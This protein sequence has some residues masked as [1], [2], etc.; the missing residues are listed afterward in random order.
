MSQPAAEAAQSPNKDHP[1]KVKPACVETDDPSG[2]CARCRRLR[3]DCVAPSAK[4][5][6]RPPKRPS[7]ASSFAG[8][9]R[10]PGL[11][12]LL[13]PT[14]ESVTPST[15]YHPPHV[16]LPAF[17]TGIDALHTGTH[18]APGLSPA[19]RTLLPHTDTNGIHPGVFTAPHAEPLGPPQQIPY[20]AAHPTLGITPSSSSSQ[21]PTP[22]GPSNLRT[23]DYLDPVDR[24]ATLADSRDP[25]GLYL[26]PTSPPP[27]LPWADA[28]AKSRRFEQEDPVALSILSLAEAHALTR[29]FHRDLNPMVAVL[30]SA[31]HTTDYLRRTSTPLFA[32]VLATASKFFRKDLYPMLLSHAT[33][34][35]DRAVIAGAEDTGLVQSLM[36]LVYW[37]AP[38]DTSAWRRIGWAI[39]MGYQFRWYLPRNRPLP[40]D[41]YATRQLLD[42]ER[43]WICLSFFDRAYSRTFDLPTSIK[44]NE[45]GDVESW[46]KEHLHL[47]VPVDMHLAHTHERARLGDHWRSYLTS[48][49]ISPAYREAI[50]ADM[51][52]RVE[53]NLAKWSNA[54]APLPGYPTSELARN[55]WVSLDLLLSIKRYAFESDPDNILRLDECTAVAA[56]IVEQIEAV[57][58]Q[59]KLE[60]LQDNASCLTSV[61]IVFLRKS[62]WR[63]SPPQQAHSISLLKRL[64]TC[65]ERAAAGDTEVAPAF[66]ARFIRRVLSAMGNQSR[67][68]SR[69]PSPAGG[70]AV[71][72]AMDK[73]DNSFLAELDEFIRT[74]PGVEE[75]NML[76]EQY[77]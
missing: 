33:T 40:S 69:Y 37:K 48:G 17:D 1:S 53:A 39:R 23:A 4:K 25:N 43:T 68:V 56:L 3:L 49:E 29:L 22:R 71:D 74:S 14:T 45:L 65:H 16:S 9:S 52:G 70:Q 63:L 42:A 55:R 2:P 24:I 54:N 6:G 34:I 72:V 8:P 67:A 46:A 7:D 36:L 59:G 75:T 11:A 13:A 28:A 19:S 35:V 27:P 38:S 64:L 51:I 26:R 61:L 66:V 21:H 12:N 15:L 41:E 60:L 5:R 50:V 57:A 10:S 30:D 20:Q 44:P 47:G 73:Q 58:A 76:D 77:W 31:L 18:F 62:F 32:T